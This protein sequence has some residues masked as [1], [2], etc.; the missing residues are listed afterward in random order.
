LAT[1]LTSGQAAV[2]AWC[3][4]TA[5][6]M[7]TAKSCGP[8][9]PRLAS[10]SQEASPSRERWW[11]SMATRESTYK[12]SSHCAGKAGMLPLHLYAHVRTFLCASMHM[13]PRVRRAPGLSLRP[14]LEEAQTNGRPRTRPCRENA[15][16]CVY[17]RSFETARMRLCTIRPRHPAYDRH[18]RQ[19]PADP[20]YHVEDRLPPSGFRQPRHLRCGHPQQ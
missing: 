13:R 19:H 15:E 16:V 1:S 20:G 5:A 10:S 18:R 9:A 8:D 2:D 3:R 7:R 6:L 17:G 12:S 14:L 11:H 4:K